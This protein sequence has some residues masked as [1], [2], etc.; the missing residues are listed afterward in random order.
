MLEKNADLEKLTQEE[1]GKFE[2]FKL[3]FIFIQIRK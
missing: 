3:K 2:I 1:R